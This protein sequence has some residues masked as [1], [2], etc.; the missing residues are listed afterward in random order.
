MNE[1]NLTLS[2]NHY[3]NYRLYKMQLRRISKTYLNY[4]IHLKC[5]FNLFNTL[6][7]FEI[8]IRIKRSFLDERNRLDLKG[9][10]FNRFDDDDF[11]VNSSQII[12]EFHRFSGTNERY[13][14]TN[15]YKGESLVMKSD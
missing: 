14:R 2:I 3:Y 6:K 8:I 10:K 1:C 11:N 4:E 5:M 7:H 15:R 12:R 9:T 13:Q